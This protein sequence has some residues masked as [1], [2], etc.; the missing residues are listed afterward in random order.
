MCW[1]YHCLFIRPAVD[2]HL[3]CSHH[4]AVV[5][6][7]ALNEHGCANIC[8]KL[9]FQFFWVC[10]QK[11]NCWSIILSVPVLGRLAIL[12]VTPLCAESALLDA[13]V[14]S[15]RTSFPP[16]PLHIVLRSDTAAGPVIGIFSN[17]CV[18]H[19]GGDRWT[20]WAF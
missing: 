2:G 3:G 11:W 6:S 10:T 14:R 13:Q 7:A 18:F 9:C 4:S 20:R 17:C 5:T 19:K 8:V 1:M 16:L 12:C 15:L